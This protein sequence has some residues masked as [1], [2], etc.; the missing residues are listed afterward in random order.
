M[1][2]V[3]GDGFYSLDLIGATLKPTKEKSILRRHPW[4][5]SGAIKAIENGISNGELLISK[6]TKEDFLVMVITMKVA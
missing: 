5:F 1:D 4:V 3:G 6:V 2:I